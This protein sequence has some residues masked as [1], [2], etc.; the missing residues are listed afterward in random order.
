MASAEFS[1]SPTNDEELTK[2]LWKCFIKYDNKSDGGENMQWRCAFLMQVHISS[3][4][5]VRAICSNKKVL[6]L[7]HASKSQQRICW[8]CRNSTVKQKTESRVV[9]QRKLLI[10]IYIYI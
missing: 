2:P 6:E 5:R 3:Y 7:E 8:K 10:P 4:T 9:H 1:S